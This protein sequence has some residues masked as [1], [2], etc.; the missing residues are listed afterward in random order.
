VARET[1]PVDAVGIQNVCNIVAK[2]VMVG[3]SCA[4]WIESYPR[5]LKQYDCLMSKT[6]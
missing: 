3:Y 1:D 4:K 6:H 5:Q 2:L